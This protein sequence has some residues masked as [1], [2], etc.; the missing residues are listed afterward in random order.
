MNNILKILWW[1]DNN[2]NHAIIENAYIK[3]CGDGPI[4][5]KI[6]KHTC[7]K[8]CMFVSDLDWKTNDPEGYNEWK[9]SFKEM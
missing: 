9:E 7:Y 1:I 8:F 4:G 5:Y 2:I 3:F 6:W